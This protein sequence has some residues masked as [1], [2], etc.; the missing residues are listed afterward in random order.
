MITKLKSVLVGILCSLIIP[1]NTLYAIKYEVRVND[2]LI[3]RE[4]PSRSSSQISSLFNGTQV[5]ILEQRE[6]WGKINYEGLSGWI[7]MQF[8]VPV[9]NGQMYTVNVDDYLRVRSGPGTDYCIL[10]RLE[11][12]TIV[13]I[14]QTQGNWGKCVING[15]TGWICTDFLS[16]I[17]LIPV[18]PVQSGT[19]M[20]TQEYLGNDHRGIDIGS[21][22]GKNV[23]V[24]AA[25]EGTVIEA[26]SN[27]KYNGGMGNYVIIEHA[28]GYV[29]KYMHFE[30]V[31]VGKGDRV[32]TGQKIGVMGTTGDSTGVHLHFQIE[33]DG[34]HIN[35]HIFV[36]PVC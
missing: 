34:H 21:Y 19:C 30:K 17:G 32:S 36:N 24:F 20:I 6:G 7:C 31:I 33:K 29:S 4:E 12:G 23:D 18:K 9:K 25:L 26:S 8:V 2:Y 28:N 5:D 3:L 35:P 11:K 14:D 16:P 10:S 13:S 22:G 27:N 15:V 1:T